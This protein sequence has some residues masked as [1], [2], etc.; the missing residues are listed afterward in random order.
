MKHKINSEVLLETILCFLLSILFFYA[1]ISGRT[2]DYVHPRINGYLWF[3]AIALLII[4]IMLL[5]SALTPK[6]NPE[7]GRYLLFFIPILFALLIP[8]GAVQSSAISFGNAPAA[9]TATI[10]TGTSSQ[11]KGTIIADSA[12]SD[13]IGA[14]ASSAPSLPKED[15]S[16]VIT[17]QDEQFARWY[18]D[19]NQDMDKYNGKT[20]KFKGQV[21]RMKEFAKN[22]IVPVR[23]AMVCCTADLQP[24]G[25]LCRGDGVLKYK[26]N[27][28]VWVTGKIK[29]ENYMNQRMPV[30]YITKIEK[31]EKAQKAYIY[32]TY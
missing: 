6:H 28:W 14:E 11:D 22:E 7:P 16:G 23:Y 31:A 10:S 21:F 17:V 2:T 13:D 19:I 30:C 32:F 24:C 1:L 12:S 3:A 26:E 8:A 4:S 9:G 18:Q 25:I 29:I 20:L 5:P 15:G 27:E